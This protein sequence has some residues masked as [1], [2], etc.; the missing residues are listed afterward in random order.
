MGKKRRS[1]KRLWKLQKA[2]LRPGANFELWYGDGVRF[3]LLPITTYAYRRR[4]QPLRIETPGKNHRVG[5]CG[6]FRYPDG[7]FLFTYRLWKNAVTEQTV[8]LLNLLA[9]RARRTGKRIILVLD[10][11]STYT[12]K[13]SLTELRRLREWIHVFWL[14]T[15]TSEQLNLIENVWTHLKRTYFSRMLTQGPN[16]FP[17]A[18]V[19]L[20]KTLALR[21]ALRRALKPL[22]EGGGCKYLPRVA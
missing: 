20:L 15:Y 21:G 6:A 5:V 7:P 19:Q 9:D 14:P 11:G 10:N 12:S 1:Q 3:D 16:E 17:V 22:P 13:R 2:A 4:G 18:V 8:G